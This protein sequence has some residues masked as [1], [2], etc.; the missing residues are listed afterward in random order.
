MVKMAALLPIKQHSERVP[1][2]N[3]RPM[4]NKPLYQWVLETLL[5]CRTINCVVVDTDDAE[6][7]KILNTQY[8]SVKTLLRPED[9]CG[10]DVSMNRVIEHDMAQL[11]EYE[12]FLQTHA[13]NP[14]LTSNTIDGAVQTFWGRDAKYD[15]LFSVNRIQARTYWGNG[16]PINHTLGELNRTQDLEPIYEENSNFFIFSRQSFSLTNS[17]LGKK[18]LLFETPRIESLE[19]DEEEDFQ[20]IQ[21]VLGALIK[22]ECDAEATGG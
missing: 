5:N 10:G 13:T 2:K 4:C 21:L 15:S 17:R 12:Y 18:P 19:I 22:P 7:I 20:F 6:F 3:F 16:S 9:I 14:L 11:S 8:P 1:G